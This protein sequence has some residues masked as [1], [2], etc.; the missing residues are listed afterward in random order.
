MEDTG[1]LVL[2]DED[3]QDEEEQQMTEE[4]Q[5]RVDLKDPDY[6]MPSR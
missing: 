3:E 4:V 5:K 1:S 6:E 2:Y